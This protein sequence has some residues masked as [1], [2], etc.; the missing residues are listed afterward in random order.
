MPD[1]SGKIAFIT[2]ASSG[3]GKG[4]AELFASHRVNLIL[5]AR[6]KE[7]LDSLSKELSEKHGVEVLTCKLD[8]RRQPDVE[9][10]VNNLPEKWKDI[11]ILINSAGLGRESIP[12]HEG[13]IDDWDEIIDTNL[14]GLLYVSRAIAPLM[15]KRNSGHIV[16]IGSTAAYS[17]VPGSTAYCATKWGMNVLAKG[18]KL[19]LSGTNIRVTIVHPGRTETE[20]RLV[21]HRGD[22]EL[23]RKHYEG[24]V[25]LTSKD[26]AETVL[27]AVN[28]PLHVNIAEIVVTP[29]DYEKYRSKALQPK[30]SR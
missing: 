4:C 22:A 26:V 28:R 24:V 7:R 15:V 3:I 6:R 27:F 1:I 5:V 2:G 25:P 8:V 17:V 12:F 23:A 9:S 16:I 19:D 30:Q 11:D 18:F 29:T 13:K 21:Y 10:T 14:K 20:F